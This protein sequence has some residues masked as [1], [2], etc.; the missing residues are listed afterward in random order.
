MIQPVVVYCS[1]TLSAFISRWSFPSFAPE[2]TVP[3]I[4]CTIHFGVPVVPEEYAMKNGSRK[5]VFSNSGTLGDN[6][7]TYSAS[8]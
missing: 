1:A 8:V 5:A 2:S 4:E 6:L 3:P 7:E